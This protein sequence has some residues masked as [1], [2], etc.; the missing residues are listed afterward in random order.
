MKYNKEE[1]RD[2]ENKS[3]IYSVYLTVLDYQDNRVYQYRIKGMT[4]DHFKLVENF[5]A[6]QGHSTSE[7][8]WMTHGPTHVSGPHLI[9]EYNS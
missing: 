9:K 7:C 8:Q 6:L 3:S 1:L 4:A 5:M 2:N